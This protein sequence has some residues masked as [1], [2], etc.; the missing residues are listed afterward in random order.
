VLILGL[1]NFFWIPL[2]AYIG[3]RPVFLIACT[4]VFVCAIWGA[5]AKSFNSLLASTIVGGFGGGASEAVGAA[6][7]N[8]LYFLHERGRMMGVYMLAIS[9]GS[10]VGPLVGGFLIANRGWQW[11]K[12]VSAILVGV[13]LLMIFFLLPET[14]YER[15]TPERRDSGATEIEGD[16]GIKRVVE[17]CLESDE[18]KTL[19]ADEDVIEKALSPSNTSSEKIAFTEEKRTFLQELNPWSGLDRHTN[20]IN[21]FLR[22]FPL[23]LYPACLFATL[24]CKSPFSKLRILYI[25]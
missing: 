16:D 24:A 9:W 2:A 1:S 23:I 25:I 19:P 12:W 7:V 22:P 5:C 3:K 20:L 21:H 15:T 6:I 17:R 4:T 8:D 18:H 11:Q 10:S 14:R 13:N